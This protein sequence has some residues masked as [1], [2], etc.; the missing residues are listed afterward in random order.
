[1]FFTPNK[2][3]T[4]YPTAENEN[5]ILGNDFGRFF[6]M[7][8]ISECCNNSSRLYKRGEQGGVCCVSFGYLVNDNACNTCSKKAKN[9]WQ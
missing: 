8:S 4:S 6:D 5:F 2:I 3:F 7:S 9:K 1:M